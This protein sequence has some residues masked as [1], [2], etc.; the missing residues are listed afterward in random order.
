MPRWDIFISRDKDGPIQQF[1]V[2]AVHVCTQ[3]I[4]AQTEGAN[5]HNPVYE[6][7]AQLIVADLAGSG[8][9]NGLVSFGAIV[10]FSNQ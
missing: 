9:G 6:Q 7:L 8:H 5:A 10:V 2:S 1:G 3:G 4:L